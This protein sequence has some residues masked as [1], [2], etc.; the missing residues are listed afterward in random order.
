VQDLAARALAVARPYA[1]RAGS[2]GAI[3]HLERMLAEGNGAVRQRAAFAR[4]GMPE[5]LCRLTA[6][7][8]AGRVAEERVAVALGAS[9]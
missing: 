7:T 9:A 1:A 4:G 2:A 6:D 8:A 3:D 5:V